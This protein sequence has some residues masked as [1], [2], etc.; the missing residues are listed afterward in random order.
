MNSPFFLV[1]E[2]PQGKASPSIRLRIGEMIIGRDSQSDIV[3]P[4]RTVSRKHAQL[5]IAATGI[6]VTDLHSR[7]GTWVNSKRT[8]FSRIVSGNELRLGSYAFRISEDPIGEHGLSSGIETE[9]PRP[10]PHAKLTARQTEVLHWLVQGYQQKE[11]AVKLN[12]SPDTVHN[13][14]RAIYTA[15]QVHSNVELLLKILPPPG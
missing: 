6:L 5:S 15:Y 4:D 14:I 2:H 12:I 11:V 7:S 10:S 13:H 9:D 3:I 1:P 8:R